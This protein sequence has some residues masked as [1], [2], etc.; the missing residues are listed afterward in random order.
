[1]IDVNLIGVLY[2][3]KLAL[4]YFRK[5]HVERKGEA[6]DLNLVIQGSLAGYLDIAGSVEYT[7]TKWAKRGLMRV[8]RKTEHEH[9]IRVNYIG[10]WSVRGGHVL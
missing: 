3:V 9:N 6:R 10:P 2:S 5:Q 7:T 8:L 1:M 4:F